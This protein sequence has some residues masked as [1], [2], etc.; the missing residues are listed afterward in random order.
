ME[1]RASRS[2]VRL[3]RAALLT[4]VVTAAML[5]INVLVDRYSPADSFAN[6]STAAPAADA[7]AAGADTAAQPA[8]TAP[9]RPLPLNLVVHRLTS[10]AII[11]SLA[12]LACVLIDILFWR[13]IERQTG[14]PAPRLGVAIVRVLVLLAAVGV[15]IGYVFNQSIDA[16]IVSSGAVG[17]VLGFAL[18]RMISDFFSGIAMSV[19]KPFS[20][21]DWIEVEG[22]AGQVIETNWRATRLVRLD[23]VM[24]VLPNS[25]IGE[26]K[27]L[28]YDR[29]KRYFRTELPVTLEHH[30]PPADAKRVLMA[31]IRAAQGVLSEP[32]PDIIISEFSERGIV[33]ILRFYIN[34]YALIN[35]I[36]DR[37]AMQVSRHLWQAGLAVPYPKRDVFYAPMPSRTDDHRADRKAL[38]RRVDLFAEL[39]DEDRAE[40]AAAMALRQ[41]AAG[42]TIVRQDEPGSPMF[43]LGEGLPEVR[44]QA[45][46][47]SVQVAQLQPGQ[48]FGERSLL[49]GE[50]RMASVVAVTEATVYELSHASMKT[51]LERRPEFADTLSRV[52]AQRMHE[53]EDRSRKSA[54]T[55]TMSREETSAQMLRRI[56]QFFGLRGT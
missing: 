53:A 16:F 30:V 4:L 49:T 24:V 15:I 39:S 25:F 31:A 47:S 41:F 18:Q 40:L 34:N 11:L 33:Y 3:I 26:R 55:S 54:V 5:V 19:E 46:G 29:P 7:V 32:A 8:P 2:T 13:I 21:G 42:Q 43:I 38:L 27:L 6:L 50:P 52:L 17:V 35:I 9:A 51:I 28:N 20:V 12:W 22:E 48:F 10:S 44:G 36:T 37:V 45:N 14:L 1:A 56:R 23:Q